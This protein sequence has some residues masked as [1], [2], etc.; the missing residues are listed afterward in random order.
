MGKT[1]FLPG[2]S[3]RLYGR[4]AVAATSKVQHRAN[5]LDGLAALVARFIPGELFAPGEGRRQRTYT[6]W[7]TFIAFLGQVLTRGSSCR[8]AVRRVQAWCVAGK[9]QAPDESTSAY[10]QARG[11]LPLGQLRAAHEQL[12][13]W[14]ER[15]G[16]EAWRWCGRTVKVL[17]GC[18]LSMPDTKENRGRWPYAG[19]QKP[20][21]GFPT[22]QLVGLFC[23]ATGRLV[24]FALDT[25]KAHEIPLARQLIGWMQPG[26]IVLTDRGFCGWGLIGLLHRKGVEV[27][28][29]AHHARKLKGQRMK[30]AKPQ[31]PETW[32]KSLWSELPAEIEVRIVRFRIAVAGFRTQEVV[33]VTT[34]LD[35]KAYSDDALAALYRR[36]WAVELCFRDIK[37]TLGL[38]VLRCQTPQLVEKEV[39][40]QAIAYN[41]VRALM[42]EAAWRHSVALERLS[43]KGTVDTLRQWTPLLAPSMFAFKRARDELL[44]VIAADSLPRRPDRSEPR[45]RKRR[46]KPYQWLTKPRHEMV[47]SPSRAQK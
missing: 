11:R 13:G 10:C 21:C 12:G 41:L 19:G 29:R 33:L 45:V 38:D 43:F 42:L 40:L 32:S 22:A 26:E 16:K 35:E 14:I 28:M 20:G 7:V 17:D 24:R 9:R 39:W 8:E 4:Q 2:F 1:M 5:R 31:R 23:L 18:G 47:V 6:P 25:W 30:W 36:R 27:V 46:P 34:L 44:R 3:H 15:H 37:T